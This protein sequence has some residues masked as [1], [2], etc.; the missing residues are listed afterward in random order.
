MGTLGA[1]MERQS[2]SLG[3]SADLRP[4]CSATHD[5]HLLTTSTN[6]PSRP[7]YTVQ[8][9]LHRSSVQLQVFRF[10]RTSFRLYILLPTPD[11]RSIALDDK[12]ASPLLMTSQR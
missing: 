5:L 2:D 7:L 6:R 1:G 4:R 11:I 3:W 8:S 9:C 10:A 12:A